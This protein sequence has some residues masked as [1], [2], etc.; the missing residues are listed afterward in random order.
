MLTI[1]DVKPLITAVQHWASYTDK[2]TPN[3]EYMRLIKAYSPMF[4]YEGQMHRTLFLFDKG[5]IPTDNLES[6]IISHE[7][8]GRVASWS[9]TLEGMESWLRQTGEDFHFEHD[10]EAMH[11]VS[12]TQQ[13]RAFD[14]A[15]F[16]QFLDTNYPE[17]NNF[18]I[19]RAAGV[20]EVVAPY[21]SASLQAEIDFTFQNTN[22]WDN[23]WDEDDD[24]EDY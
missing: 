13:G 2:Q 24:E 19:K 9:K 8:G 18:S 21:Y 6:Y 20:Q 23:E 17:L 4:S 5:D 16:S 15:A 12:C 11:Q 7:H 1:E 22:E 10:E 14:I 3:P